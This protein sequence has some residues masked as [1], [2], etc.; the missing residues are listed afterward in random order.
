MALQ[1][2]IAET[3]VG[4]SFSAAYAKVSRVKIHN[5][6]TS[7]L[8]ATVFV[9]IYANETARQSSSRPVCDWCYTMDV[10]TGDFLPGIY[11]Q[12]KLLNEFEDATDC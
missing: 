1:V 2:N 11:A 5:P 12:L 9:T 7:N 6:N 10:P 4:A 3:D 8:Y